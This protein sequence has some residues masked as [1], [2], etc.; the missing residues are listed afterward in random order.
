M[1][2]EGY[3]KEEVERRRGK[4]T[5]G[6]KKEKENTEIGKGREALGQ[7]NWKGSGPHSTSRAHVKISL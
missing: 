6:G 2:G 7:L 4:R 3:R 5:K 1:K